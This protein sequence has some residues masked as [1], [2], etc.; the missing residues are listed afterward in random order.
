MEKITQC[1]YVSKIKLSFHTLETLRTVDDESVF[2]KHE[3]KKYVYIFQVHH[4]VQHCQ[5]T[6]Q[7]SHST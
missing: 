7:L 3:M 2:W 5:E 6:R 1:A 4:H